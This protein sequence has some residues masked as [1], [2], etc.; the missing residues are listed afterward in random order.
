MGAHA[1]HC[2]LPRE[3]GEKFSV[4]HLLPKELNVFHGVYLKLSTQLAAT[5][6]TTVRE[7]KTMVVSKAN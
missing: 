4:L 3:A 7:K 2:L 1:A 6:P 5:V